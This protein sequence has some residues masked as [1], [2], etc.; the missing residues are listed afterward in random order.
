MSCLISKTKSDAWRKEIVRDQQV[1]QSQANW[2][3][4][5]TWP[6]QYTHYIYIYI[7][8]RTWEISIHLILLNLGGKGTCRN[9]RY[10]NFIFYKQQGQMMELHSTSATSMNIQREVREEEDR[11]SFTNHIKVLV[12]FSGSLISVTHFLFLSCSCS[13][14]FSPLFK[15]LAISLFPI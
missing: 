1:S 13:S 14:F 9:S 2:R 4:S 3:E 7:L 12:S 8:I 5:K 6:V 11:P 10:I 15:F